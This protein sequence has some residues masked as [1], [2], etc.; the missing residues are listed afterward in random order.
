MILLYFIPLYLPVPGSQGQGRIR[1]NDRFPAGP[2]SVHSTFT[3]NLPAGQAVRLVASALRL[4]S[5][6]KEVAEGNLGEGAQKHYSFA[7]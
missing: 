1:D 5:C 2:L 6:I 3:P 4:T 7:P